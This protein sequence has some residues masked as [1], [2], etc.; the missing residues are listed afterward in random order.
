MSD[1]NIEIVDWQNSKKSHF[2][3]SEELKK[4]L[5]PY[6]LIFYYSEMKSFTELDDHF[7]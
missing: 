7:S 3:E 4:S 2:L 6:F 1:R 5:S